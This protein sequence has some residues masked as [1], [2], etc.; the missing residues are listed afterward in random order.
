[1]DVS[2]KATAPRWGYRLV[3]RYYLVHEISGPIHRRPTRTRAIATAREELSLILRRWA[4]Q[5]TGTNSQAMLL[6]LNGHYHSINY[7]LDFCQSNFSSL[8]N[9]DIATMDRLLEPCRKNDSCVY[10]ADL[11]KTAEIIGRQTYGHRLYSLGF[12]EEGEETK[13]ENVTYNDQIIVKNFMNIDGRDHFSSMGEMT[14]TEDDFL[15]YNCFDHD[16][17]DEEDGVKTWNKTVSIIICGN[18]VPVL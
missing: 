7:D 18:T 6:P 12:D 17:D 15:L 5:D 16:A 3:L 13:D 9:I 2:M 4:K 11:Q 14:L 1:M 10:V 8:S